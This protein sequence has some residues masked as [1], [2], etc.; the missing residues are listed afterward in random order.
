MTAPWEPEIDLSLERA[1]ELILDQFPEFGGAQARIF[2][3]GWDNTAVLVGDVVFR[4][5]RRGIAAGLLET[6]ARVLPALAPLLPLPVPV[7]GWIGQPAGDY[8]WPFLGH[9]LLPGVALSDAPVSLPQLSTASRRLGDFLRVLHS[10]DGPSLGLPPDPI[11]RL[12]M[13]TR[14]PLL[15]QRLSALEAAGVIDRPERWLQLF[16]LPL[17]AA[18]P[19]RSAVHGDLYARHILADH[20]GRLCGVI[21]WGDVHAGDPAA[22]LSVLWLFPPE[23]RNDFLAAYGPVLPQTLALA[24][25]RATFHAAAV[26]AYARAQADQALLRAA[27]EA[28]ANVLRQ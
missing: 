12:D 6:E 5:P 16:E 9:R 15:E 1:R 7:P 14:L 19:A 22:D 23:I 2:G 17:P 21:D 25:L 8:P 4:F 24:R 3:R 27:L 26:A 20:S 13:A 10:L 11:A 28:L 18:R